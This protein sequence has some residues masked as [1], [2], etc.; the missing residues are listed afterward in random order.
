M[1]S[2]K[3]AHLQV[4]ATISG[5]FHKKPLKIVGGVAETR[6]SVDKKAK[7]NKWA[8]TLVKAVKRDLGI[9]C[10]ISDHGNNNWN[11]S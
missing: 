1:T 5:K 11:V 8:I 3:Y 6:T 7:T 9:I 4:R 2:T 10:T